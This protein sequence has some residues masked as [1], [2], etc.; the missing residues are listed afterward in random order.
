VPEQILPIEGRAAS[1][2]PAER[3]PGDG[4]GKGAVLRVFFEGFG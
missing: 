4:V 1:K 3:G 2:L